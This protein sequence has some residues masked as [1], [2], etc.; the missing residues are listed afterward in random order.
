MIAINFEQTYNL[1]WGE[2][3]HQ[4]SITKFNSPQ[5]T[6]DS[7]TNESCHQTTP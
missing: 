1:L 6:G 4:F 2:I 5:I 3:E 7:G